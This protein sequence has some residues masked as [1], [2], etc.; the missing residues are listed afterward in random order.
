MH[1]QH[2]SP[3]DTRTDQ[4]SPP[5]WGGGWCLG[6]YVGE[7]CGGILGYLV[8]LALVGSPRGLVRS[9]D[10]ALLVKGYCVLAGAALGACLAGSFM[11][12]ARRLR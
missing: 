6:L 5:S 11:R 4:E 8:G 2:H 3:A 12:L 7:I 1:S 10:V 9:A